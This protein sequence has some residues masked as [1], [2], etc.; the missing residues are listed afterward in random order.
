ML[1]S[2]TV[3]EVFPLNFG[4]AGVVPL[5]P[6][7]VVIPMPNS[8]VRVIRKKWDD[9]EGAEDQVPF[10]ESSSPPAYISLIQASAVIFEGN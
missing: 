5:E 8:N 9:A 7:P 4:G 3:I 6:Q 2:N 1:A 10:M